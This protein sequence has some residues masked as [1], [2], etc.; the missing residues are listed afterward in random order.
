MNNQLPRYHLIFHIIALCL[1]SLTGFGK[2]MMTVKYERHEFRFEPE[3]REAP[4]SSFVYDV[5]Y[6]GACGIFPPEHIM[7]EILLT[8]GSQGGMSP[9][10][11]WKPFKITK[12]DYKEL[13]KTIKTLEPESLGDT[14]RYKQIKFDVDHSFDKIRTWEPWV[15]AVC[16]KH[17]KTYHMKFRNQ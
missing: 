3:S 1:I 12:Q 7:N 8:G 10:A 15:A 5:P 17:R 13:L 2:D 4:L 6:F 16:K 11:T 14:A 9:G